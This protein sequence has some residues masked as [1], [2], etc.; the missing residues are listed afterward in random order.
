MET[1]L[2]VLRYQQLTMTTPR[3]IDIDVKPYLHNEN[4]KYFI[5]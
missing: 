3:Y 5:N 4:L 2:Q 1:R